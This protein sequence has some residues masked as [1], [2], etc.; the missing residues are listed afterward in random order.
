MLHKVTSTPK[1]QLFENIINY[2]IDKQGN[3]APVS[4][5]DLNE[6]GND[7]G[8]FLLNMS[9]DVIMRPQMMDVTV[10][11]IT[12]VCNILTDDPKK[13][14]ARLISKKLHLVKKLE[15]FLIQPDN[16]PVDLDNNFG[17]DGH[18][19]VPW[20]PILANDYFLGVYAS[21]DNESL[22]MVVNVGMVHASDMEINKLFRQ[23]RNAETEDKKQNVKE[24]M[25]GSISKLDDLIVKYASRIAFFACAILK[26]KPDNMFIEHDSY[27]LP[28]METTYS[29]IPPDTQCC[30]TN[31]FYNMGENIIYASKCGVKTFGANNV[32]IQ[33]SIPSRYVTIYTPTDEELKTLGTDSY[34]IIPIKTASNIPVLTSIDGRNKLFEKDIS[35]AK[36][37]KNII[38]V[39]NTRN[40][41]EPEITYGMQHENKRN[42]REFIQ[43]RK[44][45]R[46]L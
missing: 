45:I 20:L 39:E 33:T 26:L 13:E 34:V 5:V 11:E 31:R 6:T 22:I 4:I 40:V 41:K 32:H 43:K 10:P 28:E 35:A 29:I 27:S 46:C 16:Y 38:F 15:E 36:T 37:Y 23:E 30:I 1:A 3:P 9:P 24:Y 21:Q 12:F 2:A 44:N 14:A 7:K 8:P 19:H 17:D 25:E 42:T 18:E